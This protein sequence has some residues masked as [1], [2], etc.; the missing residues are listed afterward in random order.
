M[1]LNRS[2]TRSARRGAR[3]RTAS[4]SSRAESPV[5]PTGPRVPGEVRE[6]QAHRPPLPSRCSVAPGCRRCAAP[7]PPQ[8]VVN[9]IGARPPA[10]PARRTRTASTPM[11][12]RWCSST[13]SRSTAFGLGRTRIGRWA[14]PVV[15]GVAHQPAPA[16]T[17]WSRSRSSRTSRS[18]PS[19][20]SAQEQQRHLP[21]RPLR[22]A[23]L[24]DLGGD[25]TRAASCRHMAIYGRTAGHRRRRASPPTNGRRWKRS[26]VG[27]RVTVTLNG[28]ERARQRRDPRHHRRRARQRRARAGTD[29]DSG[30]P[31]AVWVR[32]MVV[33][34][35]TVAGK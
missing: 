20:S 28:T 13:A 6:R 9:W 26:I 30:R 3:S 12:R 8:R 25:P 16:R 2:A 33:T 27:N 18:K 34:P 32:K 11:A 7:A 35:I 15:D 24:D 21:A 1:F 14:G 17:T 19:T 23:A 22:A 31:R 4:W 5:A 29:H 10:W